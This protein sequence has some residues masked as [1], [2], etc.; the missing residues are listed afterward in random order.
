LA[1]TEVDNEIYVEKA[2]EET[3]KKE[4]P[5]VLPSVALLGQEGYT[6]FNIERRMR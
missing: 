3:N 2:D 6:R 1:K 5:V 4:T